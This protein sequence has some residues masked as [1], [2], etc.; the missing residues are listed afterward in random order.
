MF[1]I[2][3]KTLIA[4]AVSRDPICNAERRAMFGAD[5]VAQA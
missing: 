3:H 1:A 2:E 4:I 5:R